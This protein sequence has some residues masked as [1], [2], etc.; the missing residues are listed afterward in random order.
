MKRQNGLQNKGAMWRAR[1]LRRTRTGFCLLALLPAFEMALADSSPHGVFNYAD[2]HA[3]VSAGKLDAVLCATAAANAAAEFDEK[4]PRFNSRAACEGAFGAG[5][6]SVGFIGAQGWQGRKSGLYFSLRFDGFTVRATSSNNFTV[7]PQGAALPFS[8]R[9]ALH[10]DTHVDPR[11]RQA[12]ARPPAGFHGG[13]GA[14][15]GE[16]Q[17]GAPV[18][19]APPPP[20]DDPNFNCASLIEPGASA[21]DACAPA[22]HK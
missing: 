21:A 17:P 15:F 20:P 11:I 4:A 3:C 7:V 16:Q 9:T 12:A 14:R 22:R 5:R 18:G 6:C 10:S 19:K 13:S 8:P 1:I 2:E